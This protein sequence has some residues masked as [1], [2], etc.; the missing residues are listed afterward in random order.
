MKYSKKLAEVI[1]DLVSTGDHTIAAVCK[2]VG[3]S[4]AVYYKW[5]NEK[6][7]FMEALKGAEVT[8][9][10]SLGKLALSGL[11]VLLTKHEYEEVTTEYTEGKDGKPKIK[12]QKKVKKFIMP[13]PTA[14]IFTVTNRLP[15]DWK[16][17]S[18]IDHTTDGE[19]LNKGFY[20]F[21]KE[22]STKPDEK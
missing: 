18:K 7:E 19:S 14:V 11:A 6:L 13:N 15:D 2:H 9:L 5:K 17:V 20:D 12:N 4:E 8:R 3:I 1:V 22:V 16:H 21:L 10:E